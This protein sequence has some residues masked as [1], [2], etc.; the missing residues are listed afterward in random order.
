MSYPESFGSFLYLTVLVVN[1]NSLSHTKHAVGDS[2]DRNYLNQQPSQQEPFLP[3]MPR[4]PEKSHHYA[5]PQESP[6]VGLPVRVDAK[7]LQGE[8][9]FLIPSSLPK[10]LSNPEVLTMAS[11]QD[12]DQIFVDQVSASRA[13]SEKR[14]RNN[15]A[16]TKYRERN[17][18]PKAEQAC[19]H[20][21]FGK[22]KCNQKLPT[23][24]RCKK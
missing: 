4:A 5:S 3:T 2:D 24:G 1:R 7:H 6:P 21:Q 13:A 22:R 15:T 12:H 17:K 18:V 16:V 19:Y 23:C 20:C 10:S 11:Y 8:V 9:N 14:A